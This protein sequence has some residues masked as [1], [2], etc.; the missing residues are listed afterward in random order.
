MQADV[1][2]LDTL[3][4]G[5]RRSGLFFAAWGVA[6]KVP[7][8]LA[9]G[10]AFPALALAGFDAE[11][12]EQSG[13]ALFALAALYA[14]LPC[15]IKLLSIWLLRG[16]PIDAAEQERIKRRLAGGGAETAAP[17]DSAPLSQRAPA[18]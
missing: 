2:D 15:V 16:Y 8:A 10:I 6:T 18:H 17:S 11:A 7:L 13:T 1:I 3:R 9:V 12:A 4:S 5:R 14:L